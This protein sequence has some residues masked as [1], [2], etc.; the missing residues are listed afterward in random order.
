MRS[1]IHRI[2]SSDPSLCF[3][4]DSGAAVSRGRRKTLSAS[5][6]LAVL[7]A[8][9]LPWGR[10]QPRPFQ[11]QKQEPPAPP[12]ALSDEQSAANQSAVLLK[13]ATELK[14][15]VDKSNKDT[16]SIGVIRKAEQIEHMARGM[17]DRYKVSV[18][19]N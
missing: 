11:N 9:A 13:L 4:A 3:D 8:S 12:A 1:K 6:I 19:P 2:F 10:S 5:V 16:L 15:E 7:I 14:V 18:S 17:K